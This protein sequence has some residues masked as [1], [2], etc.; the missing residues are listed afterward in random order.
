MMKSIIVESITKVKIYLNTRIK[1]CIMEAF[2]Q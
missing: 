1:V 2:F